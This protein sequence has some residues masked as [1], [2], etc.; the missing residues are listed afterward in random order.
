MTLQIDGREPELRSLLDWVRFYR[1][2]GLVV[3]PVDFG[4]KKCHIDD[5]Q[6]LP[7]EELEK[8]ITENH[9]IGI[10]LDG[11]TVLDLERKEL[12][13]VFAKGSAEEAAK[14][15]WVAET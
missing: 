8:M 5:W 4:T 11:L 2:R 15:T 14:K 9:N 10:R 13:R 3:L 12:I 7:P 1:S 6:K